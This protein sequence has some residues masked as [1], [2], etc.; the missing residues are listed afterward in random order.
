MWQRQV[1]L[2]DEIGEAHL[3][4]L[5]GLKG[6]YCVASSEHDNNVRENYTGDSISEEEYHESIERIASQCKCGG[7]YRF[8]APAR[9]PKCKSD[10]LEE[11]DGMF[12]CYD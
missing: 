11:T 2:F 1:G 5:K 3:Q 4:Y 12:I 9:C 6:P 7:H 8:N 10:D